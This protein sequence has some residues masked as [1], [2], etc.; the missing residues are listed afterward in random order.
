M[1]CEVSGPASRLVAP[2]H[3]VEVADFGFALEGKLSRMA[4][5]E[6][7]GGRNRGVQAVRDE[8]LFRAGGAF[9]ARGDIDH[10]AEDVVGLDEAQA[11]IDADAHR[12]AMLVRLGRVFGGDG[13][14]HF[15]AGGHGFGV[16]LEGSHDGVADGLDDAPAMAL[17]ALARARCCTGTP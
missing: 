3:L 9:H 4:E 12:D 6:T 5:A 11:V 2:H 15:D 10:I 17:D 13:F 16:V 7:P 8:D 14:L 1:L